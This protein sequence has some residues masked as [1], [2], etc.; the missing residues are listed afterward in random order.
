MTAIPVRRP[1]GLDL[2]SERIHTWR[3][4]MF[5][6]QGCELMLAE[7]LAGSGVDHWGF[8]ELRERG[9]TAEQAAEILLP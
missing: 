8:A 2:E 5:L 1:E 9:A 4:Q 6:E 7:Q 3:L